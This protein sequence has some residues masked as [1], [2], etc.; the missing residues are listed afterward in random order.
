MVIA[1]A[2]NLNENR[3]SHFPNRFAVPKLPPRRKRHSN[4]TDS[5]N[6]PSQRISLPGDSRN[7]SGRNVA[8]DTLRG[9]SIVMM[10]I[11]HACGLIGDW[12]ILESPVRIAMR[13]SMPLFAVLMGYFVKSPSSKSAFSLVDLDSPLKSRWLQIG[14]AAVLVNLVFYPEYHCLDILCSFS[15]V[16]LIAWVTGRAFPWLVLVVLIFPIDPT[17]G[18]PQLGWMDFPLSIVLGF[19]AL[20]NL[21]AR[22]GHRVG[23]LVAAGMTAFYPL[24][25]S[26]TPGSASPLLL[27]FVFPAA[28]LIALAEKFPDARLPGLDMLGRNPLKAYVIQYYVIFAIAKLT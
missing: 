3:R 11:D 16:A 12:S 18:W 10:V 13:L 17:D 22:Y 25:T 20:G 28:A 5:L 1:Y 2:V 14:L 6:A 8:M 7:N 4:S 19:A 27:L 24:A 9:L 23:L 21:Q 15:L 26:L